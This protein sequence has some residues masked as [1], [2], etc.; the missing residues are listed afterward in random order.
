MAIY[1]RRSAD[2]SNEPSKTTNLWLIIYT[3]MISNLMIFFLMLYCLTWLKPE[4]KTLALRHSK[5]L[6]QERRKLL[7]KPKRIS[8]KASTRIKA[9]KAS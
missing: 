6:S 8:K 7:E 4:D 3:D 9:L 2:E 5:R 1:S